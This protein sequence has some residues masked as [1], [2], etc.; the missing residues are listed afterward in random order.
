[1]R[2]NQH[3]SE[4]ISAYLHDFL[5]NSKWNEAQLSKSEWA[6]GNE[7][8]TPPNV[9]FARLFVRR[10]GSLAKARAH[11]HM[12]PDQ[13]AKYNLVISRFRELWPLPGQPHARPE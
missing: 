10:L 7:E 4:R 5:E 13:I 8:I 9:W 3:T 12:L 1:M 11:G 2:A 6:F